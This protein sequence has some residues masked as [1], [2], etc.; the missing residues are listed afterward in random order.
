[1][2]YRPRVATIDTDAWPHLAT[3]SRTDAARRLNICPDSLDR[4]AKRG[5]LRVIK[6]EGRTLVPISE[7]ER[8]L[9]VDAPPTTTLTHTQ[10]SQADATTHHHDDMA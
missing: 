10:A 7:L 5:V 4:W 2:V 8:L 3:T 1:M 9:R 6:V